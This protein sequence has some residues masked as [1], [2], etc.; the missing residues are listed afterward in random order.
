MKTSGSKWDQLTNDEIDAITTY[1]KCILNRGHLFETGKCQTCGASEIC[2]SV[3]DRLREL[4]GKSKTSKCQGCR[5]DWNCQ[6]CDIEPASA[7]AGLEKP[8]ADAE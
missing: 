6:N 5:Q 4:R 8:D 2:K 1:I 7:E 3:N